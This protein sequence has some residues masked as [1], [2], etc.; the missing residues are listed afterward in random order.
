M[1]HPE[2]RIIQA[3]RSFWEVTVSVVV[4]KKFI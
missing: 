4:K 3:E 2:Y 1:C